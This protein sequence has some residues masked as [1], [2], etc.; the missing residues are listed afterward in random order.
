MQPRKRLYLS[1]MINAADAVIEFTA[2]QTQDSFV[3]NDMLRTAVQKKREI[4]GEAARALPD[5]LKARYPEV[6]WR[7]M[8][9]MRHISVHQYFS[10]DWDLIWETAVNHVTVDRAKLFRILSTEFPEEEWPLISQ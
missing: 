4:I 10:L 7:Q 2:G 3:A 9:G 6:P 5:G 1:D 8:L